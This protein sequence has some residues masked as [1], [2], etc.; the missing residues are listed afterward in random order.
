MKVRVKYMLWLKDKTGISEEIVEVDG[1]CSI[2]SL[3]SML[4]GKHSGLARYIEG[5]LEGR[6]EII[7]LHNSKTPA[8]GLES[9]LRDMD[10]VVLIPSVSGGIFLNGVT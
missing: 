9:I 5:I 8:N 6:S 4:G 7:V 2:R 1:E 10:E 3:L